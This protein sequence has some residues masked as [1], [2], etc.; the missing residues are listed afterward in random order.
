MNMLRKSQTYAPL[1]RVDQAKFAK[2]RALFAYW[3][4]LQAAG[5]PMRAS[6]TPSR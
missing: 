2:T 5:R 6:L 4:A 1:E 3:Q